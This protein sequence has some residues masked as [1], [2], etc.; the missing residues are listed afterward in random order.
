MTNGNFMRNTGT[1]KTH[2]A[3]YSLV[4]LTL[5]SLI[6]VVGL[7]RAKQ[8]Q[9]HI[10]VTGTWEGEFSGTVERTGTS[11]HDTFVMELK[12]EGP[13]VIGNHSVQ[14]FG[15]EFSSFREGRRYN[16]YLHFKSHA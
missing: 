16:F 6:V 9:K 12:Q 2:L 4:V 13:K 15:Y 1:H 10:Q 5:I 7:A 14:R 8:I 3:G 11:Q